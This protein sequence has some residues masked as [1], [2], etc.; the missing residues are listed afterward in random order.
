MTEHKYTIFCRA[1]LQE[2][3]YHGK[4]TCVQFGDDISMENDGT[5]Q[6]SY[7]NPDGS[8][9]CDFCYLRLQPFTM[10]GRGLL[11]ELDGAIEIYRGNLSEVRE[12]DD[13]LALGSLLNQAEDRIESSRDGSPMNTSARA[14]RKM[15]N[16]EIRRR[17]LDKPH[18]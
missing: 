1:Q 2:G 9:V 14:C 13:L 5:W 7:D 3:C 10:S 11:H 15:V 18:A 17:G 8:I 16:E 12:A 4:P 6:D